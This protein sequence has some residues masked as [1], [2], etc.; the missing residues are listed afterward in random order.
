MLETP[1]L[2]LQ[3]GG[4]V[5]TARQP[6][7]NASPSAA[8]SSQ[9]GQFMLAAAF[10]IRQATHLFEAAVHLWRQGSL[11]VAWLSHAGRP[12]A[13]RLQPVTEFTVPFLMPMA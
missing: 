1:F 13:P 10:T 12:P 4:R 9:R 8:A 6:T 2:E 3:R 11:V 5:K 7:S